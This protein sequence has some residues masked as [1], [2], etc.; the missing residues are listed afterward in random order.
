MLVAALLAGGC[1]VAYSDCD[2]ATVAKKG[3]TVAIAADSLPTPTPTPGPC[4]SS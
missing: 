3:S 1:A 2:V 4:P